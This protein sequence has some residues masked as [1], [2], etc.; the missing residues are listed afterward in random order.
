MSTIEVLHGGLLTSVQDTRRRSRWSHLGVSPGGAADER[1]ADEANWLVSN[2]AGTAVLEATLSGPA[3]LFRDG[4]LTGICGGDFGPEI[5]GR[6]V[7]NDVAIRVGPG[8]VL[9]FRGRMSGA[10]AYI[11]VAGGLQV[12]EVLGSR[13][14]DLRNGFGGFFGRAIRTGDVLHSGPSGATGGRMIERPDLENRGPVRVLP[15]THGGRA[16]FCRQAWTVA[17]FDRQGIRLSGPPI[18]G[19][20]AD[21]ETF[22]VLPGAIQLPPDGQP[23]VLLADAQPTGG[24]PVIGFVPAADLCRLAQA[25]KGDLLRFEPVSLKGLAKADKIEAMFLDDFAAASEAG[26]LW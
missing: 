19:G 24:Y 15:G 2:S 6:L 16:G 23:I 1:A 8:S 21:L 17:E 11:A 12:P 18:R 25:V 4:G 14:T 9:T 20:R 26:A 5:D 10:R 3:L 7:G 22:P 13:S